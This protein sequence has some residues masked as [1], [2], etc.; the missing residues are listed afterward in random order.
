[1]TE[2]VVHGLAAGAP[3]AGLALSQFPSNA[4]VIVVVVVGLV[5]LAAFLRQVLFTPVEEEQPTS[6]RRA[7]R[8][9]PP[10]ERYRLHRPGLFRLP[11][12]R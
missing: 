9:P 4:G 6:Y 11:R 2:T 5:L 10:P 7:L 3:G 12:P 8:E 1:M